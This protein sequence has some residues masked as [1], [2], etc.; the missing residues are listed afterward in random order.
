L[1]RNGKN[2]KELLSKAVRIMLKHH[3]MSFKLSEFLRSNTFYQVA[4][5][6][7]DPAFKTSNTSKT[8]AEHLYTKKERRKRRRL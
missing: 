7:N 3:L 6:N 1:K 8:K 5:L 2:Q 4:H